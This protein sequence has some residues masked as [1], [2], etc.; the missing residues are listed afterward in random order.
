MKAGVL[1]VASLGV[2]PASDSLIMIDDDC[3]NC[4]NYGFSFNEPRIRDV[5][6]RESDF[7]AEQRPL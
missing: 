7:S 3:S 6:L 1:D 2:G 5:S 4:R